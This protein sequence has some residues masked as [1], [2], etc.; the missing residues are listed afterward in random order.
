MQR[1]ARA[2]VT[3]CCGF[4]GRYLVRALERKGWQVEGIDNFSTARGVSHEN[5]YVGSV[6]SGLA[7]FSHEH[8]DVIFHLAAR[9][10]PAYVLQDPLALLQEHHDDALA[11]LRF[12]RP[13]DAVVV[14]TSSSEVYQGNTEVP[15]CEDDDLVIGPSHLP[16]CAYAISKLEMEHLALACHRQWGVKAVIARLFNV[17]GAGQRPEFVLPI[18]VRQALQEETIRAHGDGEQVRSFTHVHDC[19]Q[20]LI[21]LAACERAYGQIVNIGT[22][23]GELSMYQLAQKVREHCHVAYGVPLA[24]IECVPFETTGDAA[25]ERMRVRVPDVDKLERLTALR[26][27]D[28]LGAIIAEVADEHAEQ[29]G[30]ARRAVA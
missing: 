15:F 5:R 9:V 4:I 16:R 23:A 20:A 29:L 1:Q 3:G 7:H 24:P 6:Q 10:G 13:R 18:F 19:V 17:V 21:A 2:L 30:I 25:W 22:A 26:F 28:R 14:L 27:R 8:F 11:V 12:A